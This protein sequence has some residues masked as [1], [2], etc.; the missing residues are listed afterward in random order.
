MKVAYI[1]HGHSRT[2]KECSQSFFDNVFSVAPGDIFIHTWDKVNALTGSYWN[3]WK[4]LEGEA[5]RISSQ[6]TDLNGIYETYKPKILISEEHPVVDVSQFN[7]PRINFKATYA[8]RHM[9]FSRRKV[10]EAA[11]QYGNYDVY[12][13]TRLDIKYFSKLDIN[14]LNSGKLLV[15]TDQYGRYDIF[16]F[17]PEK[18][19][20]IHSRFAYDLEDF[21]Y[22]S[23]LYQTNIFYEN[24]LQNY[25]SQKG[26]RFG[27]EIFHSNLKFDM[28][29]LF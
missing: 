25:I 15:P 9:L 28:V 21:W 10:F 7:D 8:V 18:Y 11:K 29:R 22:K 12:F 26:L 27:L 5:H 14:E 13:N 2:W 17:G 4:D 24:V 23:N 6:L 20:D 16:M 19:I 3:G 1:F